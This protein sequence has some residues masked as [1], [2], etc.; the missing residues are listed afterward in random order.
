MTATV[1]IYSLGEFRVVVDGATLSTDVWRRTASRQL[2]KYLITSRRHRVRREEAIELLWPEGDPTTGSDRLRPTLTSLRRAL[3]S[4]NILT[5]DRDSIGL[6]TGSDLWI[7]VDVFEDLLAQS[8]AA[9]YPRQLLEQATALYRG[10]Y[11]P[12]DLYEDWASQRRDAVKRA[13]TDAQFRLA[14]LE[15]D[16][17]RSGAATA[18]LERLV[19]ADPCDERAAGELMQLLARTGRRVEALRVFERL[20]RA[21]RDDLGA[22]PSRATLRIRATVLATAG[23]DDEASPVRA[24]VIETPSSVQRSALPTGTVTFLFTDIQGSTAL[25]EREWRAMRQ[26][27]LLH[28][29]IIEEVV[30]D[31]DGVIVRPRGEGDSR[32]AVFERATDAVQA[33]CVIQQRFAVEPWAVSPPLKVRI[34]L[35]TGEAD[36]RDGDYYGTAVNRCARVRS[37]AHGGQTLLSEVTARLAAASLPDWLVLRDL[38]SCRLK[39][40][41]EPERVFQVVAP[42]MQADFPPLIG[43]AAHPNNLPVQ[44]TPMIGREREGMRISQ[45]L[46]A[47]DVRLVTLLGPGGVGKTRLSLQVG[48]SLLEAFDDG[49]FVVPLGSIKDA[50]LVMPSVA[51]MFDLHETAGRSHEQRLA[52]FLK[53]R[54]VLLILD[55]FEQVLLAATQIASLLASCEGLKCLVTS[56]AP[57]RISGEHLF[58]VGTLAQP[59]EQIPWST[60]QML[61]FDSIRLFVDRAIA[62]QPDFTVDAHNLQLVAAICRRVDGLPLGIELAAARVRHFPLEILL[63]RMSHSLDVLVGGSQDLPP[64]QHAMRDTIAWSY[65]LLT[66]EEQAFLRQL[67]TFVGGSTLKAA[68]TICTRS[69]DQALDLLAELVDNSLILTDSHALSSDLAQTRYRMF[70]SVREYLLYRQSAANEVEA[71]RRHHAEYYATW[72]EGLAVASRG[73]D[74]GRWTR[75][76]ELEQDNIRAALDW[77]ACD[78]R[79]LGTRVVAAVWPV[80]STRGHL[81]EGRYQLQRFLETPADVSPHVRARA[82]EGAGLLAYMQDDYVNARAYHAEGLAIHTAI[83]DHAGAAVARYRVGAIELECGEY[84]EARASFRESLRLRQALDDKRGIAACLMALGSA[85]WFDGDS[86]Q[87]MDLLLQSLTMRRAATD[88]YGEAMTLRILAEVA[89]A[90]GDFD[91][92]SEW[93]EATLTLRRELADTAGLA[94]AL[95]TAGDLARRQGEVLRAAEQFGE[96]LS[97]NREFGNRAGTA[98]CLDRIGGLAVIVDEAEQAARLFGAAASQRRSIGSVLHPKERMEHDEDVARARQSMTS[99]NYDAAWLAGERLPVSEVVDMALALATQI[100]R[101][102]QESPVLAHSQRVAS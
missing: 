18:A 46:K 26:T 61:A 80:W 71:L 62:V 5:S 59:S 48:A 43:L 16:Q 60:N 27:M 19:D 6:R 2:F 96:S 91:R 75:L 58:V 33:A 8:A 47:E 95:L 23:P 74:E 99:E 76:L 4:I 90:D 100:R 97:L 98:R 82:L 20:Q 73:G 22:D 21:L 64:R 38:G 89:S 29:G 3:G 40:L 9:D 65:D 66:P 25:W 56:R 24:P 78:D 12:D 83:G 101:S 51:Q 72:A 37:L 84:A 87:A 11:L 79:T 94:H 55:N 35:H 93:I 49:V 41:L 45:L 102:S 54:R 92:A 32:F 85:A 42:G 52:E 67:A 44:L 57:L 70:E 34:G 63:G 68:A 53:S 86:A 1:L 17:H 14:Q 28:D 77:A 69:E 13:W 39:D 81:T 30:D 36:V 88:R 7:D 15:Q 31:Y 50:S 10:D